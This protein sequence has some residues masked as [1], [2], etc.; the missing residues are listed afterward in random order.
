MC[1]LKVDK[2]KVTTP[3][4]TILKDLKLT[5]HNGKLNY[6]ELKDSDD[7]LVTCPFHKDG[8]EQRPSCHIYC[9]ESKK[10]LQYGTFHCFTCGTKGS[11]IKFLVGSSDKSELWVKSWLLSTYGVDESTNYTFD[12]DDIILTKVEVKSLDESILNKYQ[13]YHPYMT[14]RHLTQEVCEKFKIKYDS[15]TNSLVFPV[16]DINNNL[17]MCTRRNVS[18]KQFYIPKDI[19]KPVYLLNYIVK[20]HMQEVVVCESQINALT[21]WSYGIPAIALLGTGSSK[22]YEILNKSGIK[23]YYLAFDG[24][25]AGDKGISRFIKNINKSTFVD[26]IQLP[27]FKD[28]NDL[29]QDEFNKLNII[30]SN[31]WLLT[32]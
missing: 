14:Q 23:H 12:F 3:L 18:T 31:D 30:N 21:L 29:S 13:S 26:I 6:V 32:Y 25:E 20:E 22:Q 4:I 28:V 1:C 5:L 15:E 11:F 2:S 24:D 27:R 10:D 9:G 16:W 17:V 19:D 7:I 8:H